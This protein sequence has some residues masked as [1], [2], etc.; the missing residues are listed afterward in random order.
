[1]Q[2]GSQFNSTKRSKNNSSKEVKIFC[3]VTITPFLPAIGVVL[4]A[5]RMKIGCLKIG[6]S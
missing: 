1:M 6:Q 2:R 5:K 3:G 4:F